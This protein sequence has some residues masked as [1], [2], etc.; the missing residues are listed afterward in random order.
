MKS[1][2]TKQ[3]FFLA[4]L[5]ATLI[6]VAI[7]FWPFITVLV[8]SAALS[9]VFFPIYVFL[10]KRITRGNRWIASLL[11]VILFLI[12]LCIPVFFI[13]LNVLRQSQDIHL[14]VVQNGGVSTLVSK[15]NTAL[16]GFFPPGSIDLEGQIA[17]ALSSI[18]ATVSDIFTATLSTI[19]SLF[20]VII[21]MF[22]FLKDGAPLR[23][24]VITISPLSEETDK[25]ILER[26]GIAIN[27][28]LKGY[29]LIA[30]IQGVLMGVGLWV[31]GVPN[32]I[33]WGVLAGIASLIPTIGTA[34]VSIPA[35]LFL[36]ATGAQGNALGLMIWS[37]ILVGGI[38]NLLSPIVVGKKMAIH[39]LLVLFAVLGGIVLV[40]PIGILIG[41]LALSFVYTL[42][43]VYQSEIQPHEQ[44]I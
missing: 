13:G 2:K 16:G 18:N 42:M 22:Y 28:I 4:L 10:K 6:L 21:T 15:L 26:L 5:F 39:P 34:L 41:P 40:G 36:F 1:S 27:A 37:G 8:V 38:D 12:I 43:S 14:W 20:L 9:V 25:K 23:S 19:F 31:F 35:I 44:A 17:Q 32:P 7:L 30:L 11:T 24:M 33:L 3:L 29:L